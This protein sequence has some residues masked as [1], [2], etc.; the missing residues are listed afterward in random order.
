LRASA[1]AGT[2]FM[3]TADGWSLPESS[4]WSEP[5]RR[6]LGVQFQQHR[7]YERLCVCVCVRTKNSTKG[8]QEEQDDCP[9]RLL[10][11]LRTASDVNDRQDRENK[12]GKE[13]LFLTRNI[14][15]SP[16]IL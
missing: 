2:K 7:D 14:P 3:T 15:S 8:K 9:L 12:E 16:K 11:F 13:K 5:S 6:Q 4:I 1:N 10:Y